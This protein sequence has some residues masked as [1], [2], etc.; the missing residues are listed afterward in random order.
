MRSPILRYRDGKLA[1]RVPSQ[2][3][4]SDPRSR[5]VVTFISR[6][7]YIDRVGRARKYIARVFRTNPLD[8]LAGK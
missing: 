2:S 1:A 8:S 4:S 7:I 5:V 6:H 3:F